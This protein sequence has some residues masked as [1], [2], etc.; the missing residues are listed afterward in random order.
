MADVTEFTK[1]KQKSA[2]LFI[3]LK[4][5]RGQIKVMEQRMLVEM[6][7]KAELEVVSENRQALIKRHERTRRLPLSHNDLKTQLL[8]CLTEQ[9]GHNVTHDKIQTFAVTIAHRIWAERRTKLEQRVELK[10]H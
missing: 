1:L 5:V 10:H 4:Q 7:Q 3:A 2:E 6:G 8:E 9:F